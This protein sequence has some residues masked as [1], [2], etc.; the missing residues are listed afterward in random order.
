MTEKPVRTEMPNQI[1]LS[2]VNKFRREICTKF[3]KDI[4]ECAAKLQTEFRI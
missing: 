1:E 2:V 3:L 4:K